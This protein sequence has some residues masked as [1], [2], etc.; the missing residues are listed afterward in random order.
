MPVRLPFFVG[1]HLSL[2]LAA[3]APLCW[4]REAVYLNTGF[5]LQAESHS[6][7]GRTLVFRV[8]AG[9]L[10]LSRDD[11]VR[12]EPMPDDVPELAAQSEASVENPVQILNAAA[13]AQGLDEDFIRSV[14]KVESGLRQSAISPK[15][16]IGLMQLMPQTAAELGVRP[17]DAPENARGGAKYL[18][19]LLLRYHGNSVLALAAYNAGP[20]AVSHYRGVPP[21]PETV[22]YVSLV[23]REY[24]RQKQVKATARASTN[25][26]TA[27][28]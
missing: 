25:R 20:D 16:A 7:Q 4:A 24:N 12:I 11:V 23:L 18:R 28:N 15:G 6:E 9:T 13:Y 21:Y 14:A 5:S 10:E 27:T 8:G 26:P 3:I 19:E 1:F 17:Q 22:R 2:A